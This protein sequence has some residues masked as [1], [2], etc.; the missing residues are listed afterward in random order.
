VS[1]LE[2][3]VKTVDPEAEQVHTAS[4]RMPHYCLQIRLLN[5]H[6]YIRNVGCVFVSIESIISLGP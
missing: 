3:Q 1:K 4:Y 6:Y 5:L 2:V